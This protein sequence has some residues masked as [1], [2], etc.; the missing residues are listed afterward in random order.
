MMTRVGSPAVCESMTWTRCGAAGDMDS[1]V[2]CESESVCDFG[3]GIEPGL[4]AL[5][6]FPGEKLLGGN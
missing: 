2:D 3:G 6:G 4:K 5:P 1:I